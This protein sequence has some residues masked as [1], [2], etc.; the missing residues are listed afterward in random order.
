MIFDRLKYVLF[1]IIKYFQSNIV[2][3]SD[4]KFLFQFKG[5][6]PLL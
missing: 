4:I 2:K 1:N 5:I 6:K 3:L